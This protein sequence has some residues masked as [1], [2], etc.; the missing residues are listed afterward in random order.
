MPFL[1][2]SAKF[3]WQK[4]EVIESHLRCHF[5]VSFVLKWKTC[6]SLN[7]FPDRRFSLPQARKKK[8]KQRKE[9]VNKNWFALIDNLF[10]LINWICTCAQRGIDLC[11]LRHK[12]PVQNRLLAGTSCFHRLITKSN[13]SRAIKK[14]SQEKMTKGKTVDAV[15]RSYDLDDLKTIPNPPTQTE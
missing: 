11:K 9:S 6:L 8:S 5:W 2:L 10:V 13:K 12:L 7:C 14:V 4:F 1:L 3:L 15:V